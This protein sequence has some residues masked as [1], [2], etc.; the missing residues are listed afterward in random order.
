MA[1]DDMD[2]IMYK[3]L[4]YM[5][6]VM[7]QGKTPELSDMC[8]GCKLFTIPKGY[9]EQIIYELIEAGYVRGFLYCRT[10]DGP[11]I[12]MMDTAGITLSGVHFLE[13]NSRMA[14]AK[15]FLGRGFEI[16]LESIIAVL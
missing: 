8:Y 9:W 1:K 6:E 14:K 3:I 16:V 15:Q 7:K 2:V 4:R 11:V 5:Y 12:T 13:E 10:K